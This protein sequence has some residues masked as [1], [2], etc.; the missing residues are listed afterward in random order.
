MSDKDNGL[1]DAQSGDVVVE[2][3]P[4]AKKHFHIAGTQNGYRKFVNK[5]NANGGQN[6][7]TNSSYTG[8]T[9]NAS[10]Q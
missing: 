7:N 6:T 10:A 5:Q 3:G 1:A 2:L 4:A 9:D 8:P